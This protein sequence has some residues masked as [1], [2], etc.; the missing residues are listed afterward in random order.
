MRL[1][2]VE[3]DR[4]LADYVRLAL[5]EDGHAVD[6][7]HDGAEGQTLAM[8]HD[9]DVIVLDHG[10]PNRTGLDILRYMREH[11]KPTPVLMLTA[12]SAEEDVVAALDTGADDYLVKPFVVSELR[13]RVRA[14]GRRRSA[15]RTE[16]AQ[17][18]DLALNRL[19]RTVT[20]AGKALSLTPKEFALLEYF[21][22][23]PGEV[24]TRTE[25][26]EKVW[27]LQFDPGSNVVDVHVA[28]LRGKLERS[29]STVSVTTVRGS[30]FMLEPGPA[31]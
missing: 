9:Y 22:L 4:L 17:V 11:G 13:A 1:L 25:L 2:I 14:I 26:L 6:V 18:G 27:D 29:G 10:L 30:G 5:R 20:R 16:H 24:V 7:T 15:T 3:D 23:H 31:Q 12:N 28:R 8:V 21:L 19:R